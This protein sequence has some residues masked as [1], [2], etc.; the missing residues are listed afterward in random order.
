MSDERRKSQ[1]GDMVLAPNE[2]MYVSDQTKGNIDVF[3]GPT[4]QS[5]SGTDQPVIF[6]NKS[7]R[8]EAADQDEAKQKNCTAPEGWYIVLKNPA[9]GGKQPNSNGKVSSAELDVGK[10]IILPGPASF[11]LWP[12]QMAK[13]LKGH[14]LR[15]NQYL[16]VRVYDEDEARKNWNK[17]VIA[18]AAITATAA[19]DADGETSAVTALPAVK[20]LTMGQLLVIK[21]TDVSFYIPPTG[22]E[23]VPDKDVLDEDGNPTLVRE[24]VTLERLEYCLLM[25]E[26]GNKRYER[27]PAVVF[28]EPTEVFITREQDTFQVRKF[29]AIEL[30]LNS[31]IYVKVIAEYSDDQGTHKVGEELFIT[32]KDKMIYFP[33]EEHAIVKYDG[34]EIH[35]AIAIPDG[36]ARYVLDRNKG[37]VSLVKGP[38]MFLPDPRNQ[39]IVRRALPF[40]TCSLLYP[41]NYTAFAHNAKLTGVDLD[42]YMSHHGTEVITGAAVAAASPM[43][44]L[45]YASMDLD[46]GLQ[47]N[48]G[49]QGA[50]GS[51]GSSRGLTEKAGRRAAGD[52]FQRKTAY[53]EPRTITLSTKYDGAVSVNIWTG[54]AVLLVKSDGTRRIVEGPQTVLLDYDEAPEIMEL[55][56]GKPKTTDKLFRTAYLR[57]KANKISDILE[58]ETADHCQFL[59]KLSY[60]MDFTGDSKMWFDVENYV[61]FL[62]DHMRSRLKNEIRKHGVEKFYAN[63]TD[64]IRSAVL[65]E[66]KGMTFE[67]NGMHIYD[68]EVLKVEL[69]NGDIAK[70]I[71]DSQKSVIQSTIA[72]ANQRRALEA[73]REEEL[74][75][76]EMADIK[77]QTVAK[78]YELKALEADLKKAS[79]LAI[80]EADAE[81]T[82][83]RLAKELEAVDARNLISDK[84][85]LKEIADSN[86]E[87]D[88][89]KSKQQI[90]LTLLSAEVTAVVQKAQAISPDLIAALQSFSDK[91]IAEKVAESM[92]PLAI[93]GGKSVG[94]VVQG[95]FQ[96]TKLEGVGKLLANGNGG[97]QS[98]THRS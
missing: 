87:I 71:N 24:A 86:F 45:L 91:D 65:K 94:D 1:D 57:I 92:G 6:N 58:V 78:V 10:K 17:A 63:S 54:Y 3:V 40:R 41:D 37:T 73:G 27:G 68:V 7:K 84:A 80:V 56:T 70:L 16:L 2:Y 69:Q 67:E 61:K 81:T 79:D 26:G 82:A 49:P 23:V 28:P 32:G 64:I 51:A 13:I 60:R 29:R 52:Q 19:S 12:G 15:S 72:L 5:L 48:Q 33:R 98:A 11:A 34:S 62:C 30:N 77:S 93:L 50:I 8:F 66:G 38:L 31:G 4:K 22:I 47:G 39:V 36:E 14:H 97:S 85:R 59:L 43:G 88:V 83:T 46:R 96:G 55:S 95:M 90:R 20:D 9:Q 75:K 21:G 18:T 53:T 25:N 35:Y 74:I 76:Q 89:E 42:T 44:G